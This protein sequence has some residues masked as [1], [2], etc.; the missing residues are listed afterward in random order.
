MASRAAAALAAALVLTAAAAC[1]E[2]GP[3]PERK[4]EPAAA[5][6]AQW[7]DLWIPPSA[8]AYRSYAESWQDWVV[9]ATFELPAADLEPFL[10]RNRLTDPATAPV[11]PAA[12]RSAARH[13]WFQP[14]ASARSFTQAPPIGDAAASTAPPRF[15]K[16][17]WLADGGARVTV[18]LRA[19]DR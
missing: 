19:T 2:K 7:I 11:P 13:A 15:A 3:L 9:F 18:Y 10:A 5:A 6:L 4:D 12:T 14:P 17:V 1:D 16:R 8:T